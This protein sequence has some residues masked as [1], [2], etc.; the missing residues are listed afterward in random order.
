MARHPDEAWVDPLFKLIAGGV[1]VVI[2]AVLMP[3]LLVALATFVTIKVLR[4][5]W[6]I[7][8]LFF[9]LLLVV[10]FTLD[11]SPIESIARV[12]R[13]LMRTLNG[14][15]PLDFDFLLRKMTKWWGQQFPEVIPSGGL[16]GAIVEGL[17]PLPAPPWHP[18]AELQKARAIDVARRDASRAVRHAPDTVR[19]APVLGADIG[20]DMRSAVK[21]DARGRR[22]LTGSDSFFAHPSL[23]VGQ[24]G[25]GKTT[26]LLRIAY[27]A[28]KVLGSRVYFLDGKGDIGTQR[29]FIATM[30]NAG[31]EP[32]EIGAFPQAPFDGW[33]TCGSFEDRY[34]Q[35]LS[36]L[37][38]VV[39]S[40]E[41]YYEDTTR[42]FI[43]CALKEDDRLPGSSTELISRVN[44]IANS[45]TGDRR[46]RALETAM[47]FEAFFD[48]FHGGLD[49]DWDFNDRRAAYVLLR[50][51][52]QEREAGRLAEYLFECF[53][54]FATETKPSFDNALLIVDEFPALQRDADVAGL[55]ERLRS[56]GCSVVLSAQSFDGLGSERERIIG[57]A[58]TVVLHR[59]PLADELVRVA[60]TI[61]A[62]AV[63]SQI[64]LD[65]GMTGRGTTTS[66]HR[67]RVDPND[68]RTLDRGEV[69]MISAGCAERGRIAAMRPNREEEDRAARLL[70]SL[71]STDKRPPPDA[72]PPDL[73]LEF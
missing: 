47:R 38:A 12:F 50:G 48:S 67:F 14:G 7:F 32:D 64:H 30:L 36:R 49:G 13:K 3:L 44:E 19:G 10:F 9:I 57:A 68:I 73:A 35:L 16:L 46:E 54:H 41:P 20:G 63:T 40:T 28:A 34:T 45:L 37:L 31:I 27:L 71:A 26:T 42:H 66:E 51:A 33:R 43:A 24:P 11:M 6:W 62:Q 59:T 39:R 23:V 52:S 69:V 5:P 18:K 58:H 29:D 55:L 72:T 21:R 65:A 53:K 61:Q 2:A 25:T 17:L 60:G 70:G 22:W 15:R 8:F 1:V 56:F 4:V